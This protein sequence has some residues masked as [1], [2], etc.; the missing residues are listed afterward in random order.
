MS[1][2]AYAF[3]EVQCFCR[4]RHVQEWTAQS[5]LFNPSGQIHEDLASSWVTLKPIDGGGEAGRQQ[6]NN[7]EHSETENYRSHWLY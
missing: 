4:C 6:N 3:V 1:R 5:A 2:D 7:D